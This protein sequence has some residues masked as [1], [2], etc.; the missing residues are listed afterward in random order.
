VSGRDLLFLAH[1]IPYPPNKGDKT[2]A[3]HFLSHLAQSRRVHLGCFIDDDGDW[4]H[5]PLLTQVA[6]E[7]CFV[8]LGRARGLIRSLPSLLTSM[9]LTL[10]YYKDSRLS[11]WVNRVRGMCSPTVFVFSSCMAQYV[12]EWREARRII[13]FVD[14]DSAKWREYSTRRA[15]PISTLYR[16]EGN[17][18]LR[19]ERD[20][21]R[22]FDMSV[23]VSQPEAELFQQLA[24][25]AA[26]RVVAITN[27]I[28]AAQFSPE[29]DYPDPYSGKGQSVLCFTG[30]MDY[31]PNVDAVTWFV[32]AVFSRVRATRP[33][34]TF[35][36]VG[37]R[38]TPAVRK[39]AQHPGVMV[40]GQVADTRPYL[41]HAAGVVAP[42]RIARGIQ[43][44]VLEGMAM[45]RPVI[46][47]RE[48]FEGIRAEAGRDVLVAGGAD[49]FV[50]AIETVWTGE[51]SGV[52]GARARAV[53]RRHHDWSQHLLALDNALGAVEDRTP[54][55][56]F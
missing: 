41:A 9:P 14:V 55:S 39:L 54:M 51:V 3:W 20:I 15:W 29:A 48:A 49:E 34:A 1:R 5:V 52:I 42:L 19:S 13:D 37:A 40:T 53:V 11:S 7:T 46:V 27:G 26:S 33:D 2:R 25:E 24:P 12:M 28:D 21:A 56:P 45:G 17:A 47:S 4:A 16:R 18:L 43:N 23:F 31:W 8:P 38:P 10:A 6:A 44:K 35:W 30:M 22:E 32:D 36:I 50:R